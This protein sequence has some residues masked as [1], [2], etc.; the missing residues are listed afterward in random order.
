MLYLISYYVLV[1]TH[2]IFKNSP[3]FLCLLSQFHSISYFPRT[4]QS[5]YFNIIREAKPFYIK[6]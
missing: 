1:K 5:I 2:I 4:N 3:I 6:N